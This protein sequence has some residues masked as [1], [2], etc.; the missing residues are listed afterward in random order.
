MENK[1]KSNRG[2]GIGFSNA[3]FRK[4]Y[5]C[6]LSSSRIKDI[7]ETGV[8]LPLN[9]YFPVDSILEIG[10]RLENFNN[11]IRTLARVVRIS[12]QLNSRFRFEAGLKF[13]ELP[14]TNKNMLRDYIQTKLDPA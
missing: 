1:R 9:L 5:S 6:L 11:T 7:S 4:P 14:P 12:P 13:L 10:I 3:S 2:K 8:C